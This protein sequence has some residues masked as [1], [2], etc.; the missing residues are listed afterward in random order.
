MLSI[1]H[2]SFRQQEAELNIREPAKTTPPHRVAGWSVIG[3][4]QVTSQSSDSD[5]IS[6]ETLLLFVS[7]LRS[8]SM[9]AEHKRHSVLL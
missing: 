8:T 2:I 9:Q 5:Q 3:P 6:R 7:V 1:T 4:R